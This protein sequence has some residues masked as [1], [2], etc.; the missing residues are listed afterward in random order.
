MKVS[1]YLGAGENI[2]A[3]AHSL[4]AAV[5]GYQTGDMASSELNTLVY[6]FT[7]DQGKLW[8]CSKVRCPA[9]FSTNSPMSIRVFPD[10]Q[11][12]VPPGAGIPP[13]TISISDDKMKS[14][15]V[16]LHCTPGK[17][18]FRLAHG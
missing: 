6:K 12:A 5:T 14:L 9:L 11:P 7:L 10:C 16:K 1:A 13:K 17:N 3:T 4:Y 2:Y 18:L 8:R 15:Q